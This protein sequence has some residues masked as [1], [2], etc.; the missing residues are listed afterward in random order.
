MALFYYTFYSNPHGDWRYLLGFEP[1][2]MPKED[3]E[4]YHKIVWN[5]GMAASAYEPWASKM[6]PAGPILAIANGGGSPPQIPASWNGTTPSPASG[7][8]VCRAPMRHR[9]RRPFPPPSAHN[10]QRPL[11]TVSIVRA[12]LKSLLV[13]PPASWVVNVIFSTL[14]GSGY[15]RV[16]DGALPVLPRPPRHSRTLIASEKSLN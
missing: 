12:R 4:I 10:I 1:T 8:V 16:R 15:Q 9:L 2:W 11:A 7:S 6:N 13:T 5:G 3:F 14:S